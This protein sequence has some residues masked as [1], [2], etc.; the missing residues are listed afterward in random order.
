MN[1]C[2]EKHKCGSVDSTA[3]WLTGQSITNAPYNDRYTDTDQVNEDLTKQET[4]QTA[5][6]SFRIQYISYKYM[7]KTSYH[8][9]H[10]L[11]AFSLATQTLPT[12][13]YFIFF[14]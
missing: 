4:A 10:L 11:F 2:V 13:F 8:E 5:P 14:I 9:K 12:S 1:V 3:Q 6:M 7:C